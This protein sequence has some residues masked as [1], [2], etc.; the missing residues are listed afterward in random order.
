MKYRSAQWRKL[1]PDARLF[2]LILSKF[3][4]YEEGSEPKG[5][6]FT[7]DTRL[8]VPDAEETYRQM[9]YDGSMDEGKA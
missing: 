6:Y 5:E 1:T 9:V 2:G 7:R 4:A 8:T 3:N